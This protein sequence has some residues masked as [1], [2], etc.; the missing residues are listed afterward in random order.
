M[1]V[2]GL[3]VVP[4][5]YSGRIRLDAHT[6]W[7]LVRVLRTAAQCTTISFGSPFVLAGLTGAGMCVYSRAHEAQKA[8]AAHFLGEIDE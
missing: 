1:L 3:F 2:A 4:R 5:A 8:A 6:R 7:R